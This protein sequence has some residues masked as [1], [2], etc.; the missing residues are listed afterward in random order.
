MSEVTKRKTSERYALAR[1][2]ETHGSEMPPCSLC[3]KQN[4]KCVVDNEWSARCAECV[5]SKASCDVK[6]DVWQSNVPSSSDW[7]SIARQ[8]ERLE[9]QE[10]EA[11]AKILRLRKQR[12]LLIRREAEMA[13]RGLKFLD[14]LDAAEERERQ[15]A[16]KRPLLPSPPS[17]AAAPGTGPDP[18]STFDPAAFSP[19][20]W[21]VQ[22][23]DGGTPPVAPG[24]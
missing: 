21:L 7:E 24:S 20:Y 3:V 9:E 2:I 16:E 12:K 19:S 4:R 23:G 11:M 13:K 5:R 10:E 1:K 8:K 18:F 15:E 14:E 6:P 17:G 22:G